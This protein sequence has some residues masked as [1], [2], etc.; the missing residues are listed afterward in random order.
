M[1]V[2]LGGQGAKSELPSKGRGVWQG[3]GAGKLQGAAASALFTTSSRPW[4]PRGP[5]LSSG[6]PP[7]VSPGKFKKNTMSTTPQPRW[8]CNLGG[9]T[10]RRR[11]AGIANEKRR[12]KKMQAIGI[13]PNSR[14]RDIFRNPQLNHYAIGASNKEVSF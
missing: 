4:Q 5:F 2:G 6:G 9:N 10:P 12:N 7:A 14:Q 11:T 3:S 13:E 1:H 8:K